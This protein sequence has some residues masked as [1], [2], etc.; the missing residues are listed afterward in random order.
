MKQLGIKLSTFVLVLGTAGVIYS[1]VHAFVS[2]T[3]ASLG[4][5]IVSSC[6]SIA[7]AA[8]LVTLLFLRRN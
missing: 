2:G 1:L 7:A 3:F 5:G 8:M 6:L 4:I